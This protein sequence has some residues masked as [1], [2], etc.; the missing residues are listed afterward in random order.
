MPA[1][2]G[3]PS[4]LSSGRQRLR[5]WLQLVDWL[6]PKELQITLVLAGLTGFL[7]ALGS[8][9]FRRATEVM[10]WVFTGS[11][12][13]GLSESFAHLPWWQ[14][15]VVP[16]AGGA[17]AGLVL[18][19]AARF[20]KQSRTT[21]YM[22]AV[23]IGDG[24]LSTR[25]SLLKSL[26]ALF[27]ISSG[28]SIGREGPLVQLAAMFASAL[29]R[30]M[31]VSSPRLRLLVACG[32][33]AGIAAAYNAPIAGALFVA[34]V[35][36]ATTSMEIFGPLVCSSVVATLTIRQFVGA[37]P[38]YSVTHFAAISPTETLVLV[39]LGCVCGLLSPVFLLIL[40]GVESW[41][42][43]W[44]G[45]VFTRLAAGG[46]IVGVLAVWYPQ[47]CGNGYSSVNAVLHGLWPWEELAIIL[48][49]KTVAT[50][51]TFGSGAVGGVF[52]P[53]LF[54]GS[55]IGFLFGALAQAVTKLSGI[56]PEAFALIGMG[57]FLAA[58]T[59][60]PI[61]A[62]I[63]IFEITLDYEVILPLMLACVVAYYTARSFQMPG[64]YSEELRRKGRWE[65]DSELRRMRVGD[66]MKHNPPSVHLDA[67]FD[68]ICSRFT[69]L[70]HNYL[71]VIDEKGCFH[72]V[73]SLHDIKRFL[74]NPD[75]ATVVIARDIMR[76]DFPSLG[77][78]DFL[79]TVFERFARHD[80]ERLPVLSRDGSKLLVGS[81]S[82]AD[83]LL[84]F[85]EQP[86]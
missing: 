22:E 37:D 5:W 41:F 84:A 46:L 83:A 77:P 17:A 14:R 28:A 75:L 9:A 50:S 27:S 24:I 45:P 59:R 67:A 36:M 52:T 86:K 11:W 85:A 10:H 71:Y 19:F 76:E 55:S 65:F 26:S 44:P 1:D 56:Q 61:M 7:G 20:L 72:G 2:S 23:V 51:A 12:D 3:K 43:H 81:V 39:G 32:A 34:E 54:I 80:G 47:V 35:V 8:L 31:R 48:I 40:R 15:I 73:I 30:I 68:E 18:M 66:I 63:L 64:I 69:L 13:A 29:G 4:F 78:D 25:Q 58:T 42:S 21:D 53:T 38:L 33:A 79:T 6:R 62:I 70:P 82:K 57:A 60:A 74:T 16:T 49:L